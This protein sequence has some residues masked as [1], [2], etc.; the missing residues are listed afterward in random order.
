MI[1]TSRDSSLVLVNQLDHARMAGRL[2]SAWGNS[3]FE[4]PSPYDPVILAVSGHD[5]GW[6]QPDSV[7]LL[8]HER[9]RPFN[10]FHVSREQHAEFYSHGVEKV[11]HDDPYAGLLVR[12]HWTGLYEARW[13]AD[14]TLKLDDHTHASLSLLIQQQESEA[15]KAK[16]KIWDRNELRSQFEGRVWMNYELLQVWDR[17]SLFICMNDLDANIEDAIGPVPVSLHGE[18]VELRLSVQGD[19]RVRIEPYPFS[20]DVVDVS[21]EMSEIPDRMYESEEELSEAVAH[22]TDGV[23]QCQLVSS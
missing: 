8:D 13:G 12:M 21:V 14:A 16:L 1:V 2:A 19:S 18:Y 15:A 11:T 23:I 6:E 22:A 4:S 9:G 7:P 10:F 20:S 3:V 5:S 17:L